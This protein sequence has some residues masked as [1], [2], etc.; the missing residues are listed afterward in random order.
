MGRRL[1][2]GSGQVGGDQGVRQKKADPETFAARLKVITAQALQMKAALEN[3][4]LPRVG[5]IM[6]ENHKVLIDMEMSHETL[7]YLCKLAVQKGALGAKVTGG[8]RGGYMVALTPG[9]GLQEAVASAFEGEGYK[10][11]RATIGGT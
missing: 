10:V 2:A 9:R 1:V 4:D 5:K 6:S 11:I 8:G 3:G 7:D